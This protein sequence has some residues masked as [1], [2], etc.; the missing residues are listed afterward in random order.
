MS[1]DD[2]EYFVS[3]LSV[4]SE[5]QLKHISEEVN[6]SIGLTNIESVLQK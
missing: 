6:K 1:D 5:L 3:E 4:S 2:L